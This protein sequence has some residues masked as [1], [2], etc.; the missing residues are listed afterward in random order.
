[1]ER[2]R[3]RALLGGHSGAKQGGPHQPGARQAPH[4]A[5]QQTQGTKHLFGVYL[6]MIGDITLLL[7]VLPIK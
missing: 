2:G 3:R 5:A 6:I 1:M 4:T 7:Y